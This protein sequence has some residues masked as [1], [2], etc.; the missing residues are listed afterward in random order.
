MQGAA[1]YMVLGGLRILSES[2]I[3]REEDFHARAKT[4][5]SRKGR[6]E[7]KAF[8]PRRDANGREGRQG[9]GVDAIPAAED[10]LARRGSLHCPFG[11]GDI[12]VYL[13][14]VFA[15]SRFGAPGPKSPGSPRNLETLIV[16]GQ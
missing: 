10:P 15:V 2:A 4:P 6:G 9:R 12:D 5:S 16:N 7:E 1:E 8:G 11:A 13:A 3:G 14:L